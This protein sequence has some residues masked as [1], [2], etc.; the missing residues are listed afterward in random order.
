VCLPIDDI[1][2]WFLPSNRFSIVL[3]VN[4][5]ASMVACK[6][7]APDDESFRG[8][9]S[10]TFVAGAA[11]RARITADYVVQEVRGNDFRCAKFKSVALNPSGFVDSAIPDKTEAGSTNGWDNIGARRRGIRIHFSRK[12]WDHQ[13]GRIVT[14]R[15]EETASPEE[16]RARRET[17]GTDMTLPRETGEVTVQVQ[18]ITTQ[19]I[20]TR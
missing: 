7:V 1:T 12:S 5:T 8:S 20:T 11:Q 4:G 14:R 10:K 3:P 15:E 19:G 18:G 6:I 17:I 2:W 9:L 13:R 16:G